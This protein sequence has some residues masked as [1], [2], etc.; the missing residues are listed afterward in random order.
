MAPSSAASCSVLR[1]SDDGFY[2]AIGLRLASRW[3]NAYRLRWLYTS[4]NLLSDGTRPLIDPEP[5]ALLRHFFH[6]H[7][8]AHKMRALRTRRRATNQRAIVR[9]TAD[10]VSGTSDWLRLGVFLREAQV[11]KKCK[12]NHAEHGVVVK[13]MEAEFFL[14]LKCHA[15]RNAGLLGNAVSSTMRVHLHHRPARCICQRARPRSARRP[16]STLRRSDESAP[17][18]LAPRARQ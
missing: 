12:G 2:T 8:R 14:H 5:R 17:S 4:L 11:L 13:V 7:E 3:D 15:D 9:R 6:R 1:D 10:N 16:T 18:C